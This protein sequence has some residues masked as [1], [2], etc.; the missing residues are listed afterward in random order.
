MG[1]NSITNDLLVVDS[2][3]ASDLAEDHDHTSL[4]SGLA[5]N[6]GEGVDGEGGIENSIRARG[7]CQKSCLK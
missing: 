1:T 6:L 3:W 7:L 2:S 4:G 5:S